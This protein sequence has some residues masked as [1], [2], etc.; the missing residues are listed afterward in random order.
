[1][2]AAVFRKYGAPEVVKIEMRPKPVP[3]DY[4]VLI[5]NYATAVNSGDWKLRQADPPVARLFIG[6]FRPGKS[7]QILGA[8]FA[9]IVESVGPRVTAFKPGDHVFGATGF[10]LVT[11]AIFFF[12][13]KTAYEI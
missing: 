1:M 4:Q 7:K 2:Q 11:D 12:K 9:G 6:L 8:A 5:R 3:G 10:A 13:Q